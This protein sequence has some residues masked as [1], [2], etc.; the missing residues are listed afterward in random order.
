MLTKQ[1]VQT[2]LGLV[3]VVFITLLAIG[4]GTDSPTAPTP[5]PVDHTSQSAAG[6]GPAVSPA[7]GAV[8]DIRNAQPAAEHSIVITLR[9]VTPYGY[10]RKQR[11][12]ARLSGGVRLDG[13]SFEYDAEPAANPRVRIAGRSIQVSCKAW[14][15]RRR[16]P[17]Q[18]T[19]E[20]GAS[21]RISGRAGG[22]TVWSNSL[23]ICRS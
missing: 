7:P 18:V 6:A 19:A 23:E 2:S 5:A 8:P 20:H 3:A 10:W 1:E 12:D 16:R 15:Y 14:N 21:I 17:E 11:I 22:V 9:D 13:A 4:C